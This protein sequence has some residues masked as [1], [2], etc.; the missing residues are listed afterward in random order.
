ML[1]CE[2]N[3]IP[4]FLPN[5]VMAGCSVEDIIRVAEATISRKAECIVITWCLT[6]TSD[7]DPCDPYFVRLYVY[8]GG[9]V[10]LDSLV[11]LPH[12]H[13]K[14]VCGQIVFCVTLRKK[15]HVVEAVKPG[16]K[17][18]VSITTLAFMLFEHSTPTE[19]PFCT[20]EANICVVYD[21]GGHLLLEVNSE[22][23][24]K[25]ASRQLEEQFGELVLKDHREKGA[26][27]ANI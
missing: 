4:S 23:L 21:G 6:V 17:L 22:L 10:A 11:C 27:I 9:E 13:D 24:S 2:G 14:Q 20:M 25:D 18:S 12:V 16:D 5:G 1:I 7:Y 8:R 19:M 26:F 3:R 15:N